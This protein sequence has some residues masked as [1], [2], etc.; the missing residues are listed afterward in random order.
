MQNG[1]I[2]LKRSSSKTEANIYIL[3]KE[4]VPWKMEVLSPCC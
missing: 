1:L 4:K 3:V 2:K